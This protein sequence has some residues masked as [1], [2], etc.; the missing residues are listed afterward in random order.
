[1]QVNG[2][3]EQKYCKRSLMLEVRS[4]IHSM[5]TDLVVISREITSDLQIL[6]VTVNKSFK[7]HLKQLYSD[8]FSVENDVLTPTGKINAVELLCP[9]IKTSPQLISQ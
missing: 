4:V 5:N 1:M 8:Q 7:D 3:E 9:W 2:T 6:D